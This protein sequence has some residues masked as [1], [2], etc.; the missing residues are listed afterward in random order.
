MSL[1]KKYDIT[2]K[3]QVVNSEGAVLLER[4]R[5]RTSEA[6][7]LTLRVRRLSKGFKKTVRPVVMTREEFFEKVVNQTDNGNI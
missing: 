7:S 2:M 1:N 6:G 5:I 3:M 4:E